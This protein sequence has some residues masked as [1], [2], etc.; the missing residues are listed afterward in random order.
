MKQ[1][2]YIIRFNENGM[3]HYGH[4]TTHMLHVL[5][6]FKQRFGIVLDYFHIKNE[7]KSN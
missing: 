5:R 7:S 2:Y 3:R 4:D 1:G 6:R